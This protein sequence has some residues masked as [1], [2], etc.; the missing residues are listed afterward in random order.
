MILNRLLP[1]PIQ[2]WH[3]TP[4]S[5]KIRFPVFLLPARV[6]FVVNG[7]AELYP[8]FDGKSII[9]PLEKAVFQGYLF[10]MKVQIS[11]F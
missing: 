5:S 10:G 7:T 2:R 6:I 9:S 4:L 8:L 1:D 11:G 3:E